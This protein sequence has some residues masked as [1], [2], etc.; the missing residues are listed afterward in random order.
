M[1]KFHLAKLHYSTNLIENQNSSSFIK[2]PIPQI[3]NGC[4]ISYPVIFIWGSTTYSFLYFNGWFSNLR[5]KNVA[6]NHQI[7]ESHFFLKPGLCCT[8]DPWGLFHH[9]DTVEYC[10]LLWAGEERQHQYT[11]KSTNVPLW[12]SDQQFRSCFKNHT[13]WWRYLFCV[14]FLNLISIPQSV[15]HFPLWNSSLLKMSMDTETK[16]SVAMSLQ[17]FYNECSCLYCTLICFTW[18]H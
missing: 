14:F 5:K 12:C 9:Q 1:F 17:K 16:H 10:P 3:N 2:L 11:V 6:H 18:T 13:L 7:I 4:K 8:R 15:L